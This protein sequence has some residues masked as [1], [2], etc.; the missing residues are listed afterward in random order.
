METDQVPMI[1]L[2]QH[3]DFL[4]LLPTDDTLSDQADFWKRRRQWLRGRL[5]FMAFGEGDLGGLVL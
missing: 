3:S 5:N 1:G 4:Y 2:P